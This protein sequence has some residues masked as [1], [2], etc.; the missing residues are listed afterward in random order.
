[1]NFYKPKNLI[2]L[3]EI[4]EKIKGKKYFLAGGTDINV[5]IK[6]KIITNE[7][8]IYINELEELKGIRETEEDLILGALLSYKELLDSDLIEKHLPFLKNSLCNFASPILQTMAT[9]GGNIANGSPTADIIPLL[10]VLDANIILMAKSKIRYLLLNDFFIGYKK[11]NMKKNEIIGGVQIAKNAEKGYKTYYRKVGSRKALTI[12][13]VALAGLKKNNEFKIA[14]GSL[15]EY[16]RRLHKI[17]DYLNVTTSPDS[18]K[19]EELLQQEITPISDMRSD[20][21]YRFQVCLNLLLN[22]IEA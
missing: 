19:I 11:F 1:M 13:K 4:S 21:D 14:V 16:P 12:A 7:P 6:N 3:F 15:N 17:E 8:I 20:K 22:F 2:E 18:V 10:L 9:I 5:Q